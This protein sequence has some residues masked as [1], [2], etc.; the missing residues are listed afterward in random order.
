MDSPRSMHGGMDSPRSMPT[1][2][3]YTLPLCQVARLGAFNDPCKQ[4]HPL[5]LDDSLPVIG[6]CHRL[7]DISE[8][9][10]RTKFS[11]REKL[12]FPEPPGR[13][14]Y[15]ARLRAGFAGGPCAPPA[16]G[17]AFRS[18]SVRDA[19]FP[20]CSAASKFWPC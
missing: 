15:A 17:N 1:F 12:S 7:V 2:F 9:N 6:A 11:L 18:P 10:P 5:Q 14:S 20:T 4:L 19:S 16:H 3:T 8:G 13:A